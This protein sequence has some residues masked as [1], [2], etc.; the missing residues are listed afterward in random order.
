MKNS[1]ICTVPEMIRFR[2]H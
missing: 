2:S 1:S